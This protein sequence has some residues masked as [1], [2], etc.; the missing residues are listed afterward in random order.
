MARKLKVW[1]GY[2]NGKSEFVVSSTSIKKACEM[3]HCS[4]YEFKNYMSET[5]NEDDVKMASEEGVWK[6]EIDKFGH[7][8]REDFKRI[9]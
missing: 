2:L 3:L 4:Y 1:S 6:C 8:K 7:V 9:V 5:V